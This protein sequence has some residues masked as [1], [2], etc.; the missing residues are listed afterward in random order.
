MVP[1]PNAEWVTNRLTMLEK[2]SGELAPAAISVAPAT[3]SD[4]SKYVAMMFRAGTKRSSVTVAWDQKDTPAIRMRPIQVPREAVTI[5]S[6]ESMARA[7]G[8]GGG[9]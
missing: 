5:S 9:Q 4:M 6:P 1:S 8:E 2:S 7:E 3:S